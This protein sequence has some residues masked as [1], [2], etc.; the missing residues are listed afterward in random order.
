M[1]GGGGGGGS[2]SSSV[3]DFAH[4]PYRDSKLTRLLRDSLG[5]S[6][7]TLMIAC[8]S[9]AAAFLDESLNT[10]AYASRA[11]CIENIPVLHVDSK[12]A[13]IMGLRRDA[14]ASRSENALLRAKFSLPADGPIA[15]LLAGLPL[16]VPVDT[17][18]VQQ[19]DVPPVSDVASQTEPLHPAHLAPRLPVRIAAAAEDAAGK[20]KGRQRGRLRNGMTSMRSGGGGG[21]L[22]ESA[23]RGPHHVPYETEAD[24]G[25]ADWGGSGG[26]SDAWARR[27]P[28]LA[29]GSGAH[30]ADRAADRSSKQVVLDMH[31]GEIAALSEET[32]VLRNKVVMARARSATLAI[33]LEESRAHVERLTA[34]ADAARRGRKEAEG[35]T[36]AVLAGAAAAGWPLPLALAAPLGPAAGNVVPL[37]VPMG[38]RGMVGGGGGGSLNPSSPRTAA[39]SLTNAARDFIALDNAQSRLDAEL[40]AAGGAGSSTWHDAHMQRQMNAQGAALKDAHAAIMRAEFDASMR[41][42]A[43]VAARGPGGVGSTDFVSPSRRID[44]RLAAGSGSRAVHGLSPQPR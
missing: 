28:G 42:A 12:D 7:L 35:Q 4:V 34:E 26:G 18:L 36:Q 6:A 5:G 3:D 32:Q 10:L 38:G 31:Q 40:R 43:D 16:M 33:A 8:V 19:R 29:A 2:G 37:A 24:G 25:G 9:P 15:D 20:G 44:I 14:R 11:S 22:V 30:L 39:A 41:V 27:P 13:I 23:E 21:V 1:T 17:V